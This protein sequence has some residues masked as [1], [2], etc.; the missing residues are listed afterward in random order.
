MILSV[1]FVLFILGISLFLLR[2]GKGTG[3]QTGY[4]Y[5]LKKGFKRFL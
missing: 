2:K 4:V 3:V 5:W 1:L